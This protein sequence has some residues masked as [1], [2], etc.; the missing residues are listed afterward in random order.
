MLYGMASLLSCTLNIFSPE[1][2][3]IKPPT[4]T[5]ELTIKQVEGVV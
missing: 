4:R 5:E 3:Y 1:S 2:L